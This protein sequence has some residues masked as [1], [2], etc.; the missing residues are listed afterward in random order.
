MPSEL[1]DLDLQ[2]LQGFLVVQHERVEPPTYCVEWCPSMLRDASL[3]TID[4]A[5]ALVER[6]C[7][8]QDAYPWNIL[9]RGHKPFFVDLTSIVPQHDKIIWPAYAQLQA[10]ALRPLELCSHGKG[11]LAR[12]LMHDNINGITLP[13]YY[14]HLPG[15]SWRHPRAT[16]E[17]HLDRMLQ[18]HP[19][20][21]R[22]I[23]GASVGRTKQISTSIRRRF[24]TSIRGRLERFC[25]RDNDDPWQGY[26]QSIPSAVDKDRKVEIVGE[27]LERF[28][29]E[30]VTDLGCNTGVFS[31]L[32]AERGARVISIDSSENCIS[33]L[34]GRARR[35]NLGI[36]PVVSDVLCPTP[37]FG[38]MGTQYPGLIQRAEAD[39]VLCLGLMHHLHIN[40]RQ[41]FDRIASLVAT[42]ARRQ[43]IFEF[44]ARND[45]N[46]ELLDTNRTIDYTLDSVVS[47]LSAHFSTIQTLESDRETRR[48]LICSKQ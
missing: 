27:L 32:A 16:L 42:L 11:R 10:F 34:Y 38:F 8:L 41:S 20:F 19:N 36:N 12:L 29:P 25:F 13:E 37:P 17:F 31:V 26:Y 43:L 33:S 48:I 45:A 46:V 40:G 18:R 7:V 5:L 22:R 9:W 21:K 23:L 28:H 14:R 30:T 44:V 15:W 4:L 1:A 39:L 35:Y 47:T 6:R 2:E 3:L 24:L